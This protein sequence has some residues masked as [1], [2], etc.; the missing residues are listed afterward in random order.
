MGC[1]L[2]IGGFPEGPDFE[3]D[4]F[5]AASPFRPAAVFRRGC[6]PSPSSRRVSLYSG[7]NLEVSEADGENPGQ[8]VEDAMA[9]LRENKAELERLMALPNLN[10]VDLDFSWNFPYERVVIRSRD[11]PVELLR[12]CANL[13]I[14]MEVSV[15]GHRELDGGEPT[16]DFADRF[17]ELLLKG[18]KLRP[19]WD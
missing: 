13:G 17:E 12:L 14:E 19:N 8:Q 4:S 18:S 10:F 11:F 5:L 6:K 16:L 15:W 3:V 2:R 9:F 7:F 1:Y